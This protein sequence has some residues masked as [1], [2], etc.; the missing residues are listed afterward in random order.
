[1][2]VFLKKLTDEGRVIGQK[3]F[4]KQCASGLWWLL[5][6]QNVVILHPA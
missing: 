3:V 2:I 1:M 5:W 6:E 4:M